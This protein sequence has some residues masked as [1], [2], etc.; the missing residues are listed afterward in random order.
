MPRQV[1]ISS[2]H[3]L[4]GCLCYNLTWNIT[5]P[6]AN[7]SVEFAPVEAPKANNIGIVASVF[8]AMMFIGILGL[9]I[10][11]SPRMFLPVKLNILQGWKNL[12]DLRN[13]YHTYNSRHNV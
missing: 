9:D 13:M 10:L 5:D 12:Q 4:E 11:T 1:V 2:I 8:V 7:Q 6:N 3:M